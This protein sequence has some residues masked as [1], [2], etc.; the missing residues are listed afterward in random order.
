MK[1]MRRLPGRSAPLAQVASQ[2]AHALKAR[3]YLRRQRPG[4]A[5][6]LVRADDWCP[7]E[8]L[9]GKPVPALYGLWTLRGLRPEGRETSR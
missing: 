4:L 9:L 7:G 6:R 2:S 8:W 3:A 1:P 5:E